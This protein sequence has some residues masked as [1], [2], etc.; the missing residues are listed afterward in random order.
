MC[1][2]LGRVGYLL[3]TPLPSLPSQALNYGVRHLVSSC[4]PLPFTNFLLAQHSILRNGA[5]HLSGPS[6]NVLGC[7]HIISLLHTRM[8][9]AD[10]L[11]LSHP[12]TAKLSVT[13]PN[14]PTDVHPQSNKRRNSLSLGR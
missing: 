2:F 13:T 12:S 14:T 10:L 7:K 4:S 1:A 3:L 8:C 6:E 5:K 9:R 11:H